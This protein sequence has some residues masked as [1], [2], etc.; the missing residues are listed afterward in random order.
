M[1]RCGDLL[2]CVWGGKAQIMI[3]LK[4]LHR[5][6]GVNWICSR[7]GEWREDGEA[8][9]RVQSPNWDLF[10]K[11]WQWRRLASCCEK[12][13]KKSHV[14]T[15]SLLIKIYSVKTRTESRCSAANQRDIINLLAGLKLFSASGGLFV[16]L[17]TVSANTEIFL[18]SK[19]SDKPARAAPLCD[20]RR[21]K[22]PC[23]PHRLWSKA[24][25]I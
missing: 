12:Q 21:R 13:K 20:R 24:K 4:M 22:N 5:D 16:R 3:K 14:S 6:R 8:K 1:E 18:P 11:P 17:P 19:A 2:C 9:E 7:Q 15:F 10:L 23:G 25:D